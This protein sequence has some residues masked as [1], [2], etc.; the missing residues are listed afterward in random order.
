MST[1]PIRVAVIAGSVREG[2]FGPTVANWF[3]R[4]A[5][6]RADITVDYIDLADHPLSLV[7][8][9][10]PDPDTA[11]VLGELTPK[12]DAADAFVVVTPEYNHGYPAS[13][14][15]LIDWHYPQWQAKPVAFV[16][17][18]GRGGGLRAVEQLRH[19]FAE[20][21]AV[22]IRDVVSFHDAWNNFD[23]DGEIKDSDAGAAAAKVM[24]D[25][26]VWWAATLR[27][28]RVKRQYGS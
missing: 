15:N 12:L 3:V 23:A 2:R 16:S 27:D 18:G 8:S 7:I 24:V 28:G 20:L 26:L 21:H 13:L 10:E 9:R 1:D 25:Q 6:Q 17:Y 11:K 22:T 14:K 5:E 19:V 4:E